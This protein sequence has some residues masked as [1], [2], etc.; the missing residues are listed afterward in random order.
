MAQIAGDVLEERRSRIR[1]RG[2]WSGSQHGET[3][4][5]RRSQGVFAGNCDRL[6]EGA[7]STRTLSTEYATSDQRDPRTA[8]PQSTSTALCGRKATFAL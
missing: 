5:D 4:G 1:P 6:R 2:Q 8:A 3:S 7:P